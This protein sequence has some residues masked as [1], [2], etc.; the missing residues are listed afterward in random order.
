MAN[1]R[2]PFFTMA[3]TPSYASTDELYR[4]DVMA[5]VCEGVRG[6]SFW[7]WFNCMRDGAE[8]SIGDM[9][10]VA[11]DITQHANFKDF[12]PR[13][14][15]RIGTSDDKF[16]R[17]IL[18]GDVIENNQYTVVNG[19]DTSLPFTPRTKMDKVT[20]TCICLRVWKHRHDDVVV[21]LTNS[22]EW[23]VTVDVTLNSNV[24]PQLANRRLES[25][26]T[27]DSVT[28]DNK[29]VFRVALASFKTMVYQFPVQAPPTTTTSKSINTLPP[30]QSSSTTSSSTTKTSLKTTTKNIYETLTST[31][32]SSLST[33]TTTTLAT[34]STTQDSISSAFQIIPN[35][36]FIFGMFLFFL[37]D[38]K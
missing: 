22:C 35:F 18:Y 16:G 33:T 12:E 34:P 10:D 6:F 27:K 3:C 4:H 25:L 13:P 9:I 15:V 28:T 31:Q 8:E 26:F 19:N 23:S 5:A 2:V 38:N 30:E 36:I 14:R 32:S 29:G 11:A 1:E 24:A 17:V 37:N 7:S 21:L 20:M